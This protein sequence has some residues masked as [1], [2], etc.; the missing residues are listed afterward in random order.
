MAESYRLRH[1]TLP[2]TIFEASIPRPKEIP[3]DQWGGNTRPLQLTSSICLDFANPTPFAELEERPA[4]I[5]APARTWDPTVGNAMWLQARQ[6]ASE[7]ESVVLWCDGGEGGVSGVA[8]GGFNDV[9]QVGPGSFVRTIGVQYPFDTRR[10]LFAIFGDSF[11]ILSWMLVLVPGLVSNGGM[12][13]IIR[14]GGRASV[15][16][17]QRLRGRRERPLIQLDD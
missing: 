7:L 17:F 2:P 16:H 6:R 4:L 3:K 10:S 11:L 14:Q 9:T 8:G 15:A 1:S 12:Q 13:G 5:L